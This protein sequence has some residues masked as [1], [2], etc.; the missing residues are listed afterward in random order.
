MPSHSNA[1]RRNGAA[2]PGGGACAPVRHTPHQALSPAR[3]RL[4]AR[5]LHVGYVTAR[6]C[7]HLALPPTPTGKPRLVRYPEN[8]PAPLSYI[9]W[10]YIRKTLEGAKFSGKNF[11]F[12]F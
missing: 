10:P 8:E 11:F 6:P 1:S 7:G 3:S 2:A 4:T 12:F 5:H 9:L